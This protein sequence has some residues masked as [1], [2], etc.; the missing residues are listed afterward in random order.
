VVIWF[1]MARMAT[2]GPLAVSLDCPAGTVQKGDGPPHGVFARCVSSEGHPVGPWRVWHRNGTLE[3]RTVFGPA[4]EVHGAW[5]TWYPSGQEAV[6]QTYD[7]GILHGPSTFWHESGQ[8]GAQGRFDR[9]V[10][11]G[12]HRAWD[13]AGQLVAEGALHDG[14]G[15][16]T[17]WTISNGAVQ[18]VVDTWQGGQRTRQLRYYA[19][20]QLA[21]DTPFV[22][23]QHHGVLLEW[24]ENGQLAKKG[25]YRDGRPIGEHD[26]W[27]ADG[28]EI[29][30]MCA[31]G[32]CDAAPRQKPE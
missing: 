31:H 5:E 30:K 10:P 6:L 28:T 27:N 15:E 19:S 3:K 20:G 32:P 14:T 23:G 1:W 16:I 29:E 21:A 8:V 22:G 9:G 17:H 24:H 25:A 2:A 12:G 11:V 18:K 26:A 7:H 13:V 4:G